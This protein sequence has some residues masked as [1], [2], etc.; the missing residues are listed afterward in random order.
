VLLFAFKKNRAG[1]GRLFMFTSVSTLVF[2]SI[3]PGVVKWI[4]NSILFLRNHAGI[5]VTAS[6]TLLLGLGLIIAL[7]LA[8]RYRNRLLQL[9]ILSFLLIL[10]GASTFS[11]VYIRSQLN[12]AI[13]ENDPEN[14][15]N[16]ISYINREQYGDWSI[17]ERRAPLWEYQ[18]KKMYL[19]YLGWQFI[20]KGSALGADGFLTD[21]INVNG[22]WGIPFLVGILGMVYHFSR[23]PKRAFSILMLFLFTGLFIVIYLNQTD[24][25]PRERDY[26]FVASFFA[27]AIWIG[28]G[29]AGI[30]ESIS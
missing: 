2:V 11:S 22:L 21:T 13:D 15:E 25:Q 8:A 27:F 16:L 12:P 19:R 4:P 14:L 10:V 1:Y 28:A 5:A 7:V 29:S 24:P 6:I 17:I 3:Y 18:I 26:V 9:T 20:G 23:D 30:L